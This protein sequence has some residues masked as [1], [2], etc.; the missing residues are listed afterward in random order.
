MDIQ[1]KITQAVGAVEDTARSIAL[2]GAAKNIKKSAEAAAETAESTKRKEAIEENRDVTT[3]QQYDLAEY[4][5][6]RPSENYISDDQPH[7]INIFNTA[8]FNLENERL[9]RQLS[10][11]RLAE[12]LNSVRRK[13]GNNPIPGRD[14]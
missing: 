9:A 1:S 3:L 6:L 11:K 10:K 14:E 13:R 4:A 2:T 5:P 8:D 7:L 12:Q